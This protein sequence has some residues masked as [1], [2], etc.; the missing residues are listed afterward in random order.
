MKIAVVY[1]SVTGNTRAIA[2]ELWKN[3]PQPDAVYCGGP[4][5]C[6]EAE[7]Y[8][9]GSWTDKG[10]CAAGIAA[11]CR[12]LSG[13]QI[14]LFGTCGFGGSEPYYRQLEE[15]FRAAV[16]AGNR[17]LGCFYCQGKMPPA[18]RERYAGMLCEHPD[19]ARIQAMLENFDR[20]L[21][22]PDADDLAAA[23]AFAR[24]M[25]AEAGQ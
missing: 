7:L 9:I 2:E 18:V 1:E 4:E 23:G 19:D 20:A 25:V 22:H 5:G 12:T 13:K 6:P 15:R 17:V 24:R 21:S 8:L 10:S 11:F 14:A 16:P 3:C